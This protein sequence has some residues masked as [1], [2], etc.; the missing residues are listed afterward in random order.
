[1]TEWFRALDLKFGDLHPSA[2]VCV[3]L[4]SV[5]PN[6]T[7]RLVNWSASPLL[8]FLINILFTLLISTMVL[9]TFDTSI[10]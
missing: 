4:F 8:E 3:D 9:L 2:S 1:M 7:L 5:I 6:S 10:K